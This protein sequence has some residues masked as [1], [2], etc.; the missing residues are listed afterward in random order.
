MSQLPQVIASVRQL[1]GVDPRADRKA[2]VT[3]LNRELALRDKTDP[4]AAA[5]LQADERLLDQAMKD[6][7]IVAASRPH[8]LKA[9]C[10]DRNGAKACLAAM[11]GIPYVAAENAKGPKRV[12]ANLDGSSTAATAGLTPL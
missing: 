10:E 12:R 1:L 2:F 3:A 9:L 5:Q 8:W 7:K 11:S 4:Q 6:G